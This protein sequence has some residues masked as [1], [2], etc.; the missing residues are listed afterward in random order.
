[1]V[2]WTRA[3]LVDWTSFRKLG[4]QCMKRVG[5]RKEWEREM[6]RETHPHT[7]TDRQEKK[8]E[9]DRGTERR[10]SEDG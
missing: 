6:E 8:K 2:V 9:R 5:R 7:E 1:M 10:H 3:L 4:E